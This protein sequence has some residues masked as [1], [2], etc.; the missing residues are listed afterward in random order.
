MERLLSTRAQN[1]ASSKTGYRVELRETPRGEISIH[2]NCPPTFFTGLVLDSGLGNFAHYSSIIQKLEVFEKI[3]SERD[4]RVCLVLIEPR[5]VIGYAACWYPDKTE[6]WSKLGDLMYE[7]GAVEVS[8]NFRHIGIAQTVIELLMAEEFFE[9]KIAYMNG[10]SWHWDLDGS[11]LS[12][13]QYRML[14]LQLLKK[15]GFQECYTNE[16]NIALREENLFMARVGSR[17]SD[18]DRKKFRNLRFGITGH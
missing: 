8:R 13:V 11:H 5:T 1:G 3:A 15:H 17:V 4:G 10:F 14:M 2:L 18:E 7:M 6:R 12:I 16:P 9:E